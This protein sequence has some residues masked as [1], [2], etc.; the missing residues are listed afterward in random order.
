MKKCQFCELKSSQSKLFSDAKH[1]AFEDIDKA[2]A[3]QYVLVC[4]DKHIETPW[5]W[6]ARTL[7]SR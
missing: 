5:M 3:K 6:K 7:S 2:T 1:F 4:T